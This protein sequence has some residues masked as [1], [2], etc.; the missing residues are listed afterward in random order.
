MSA[1][2]PL[3]NFDVVIIGTGSGNSILTPDFDGLRVAIVEKDVFGGTCLNRGCIPTKMFVY[4]ADVAEHIRNSAKYGIDAS[5]DNVRWSDIV[6]RVFGRIDPIP[7]NGKAYR[8]SQKN[9]TV[10]SGSARFVSQKVLEINGNDGTVQQITGTHIVIAA[11]ARPLIP[12][13]DGLDQVDYHTSDTIMRVP[14]LPKRLIIL[15][16]GYIATEM[17]H[18]FGS[19]GTEIV[20]IN[21]SARMLAREDDAVSQRFTEIY[22][23]RFECHMNSR[24]DH[25]KQ[26]GDQIT[27]HVHNDKGEHLDITGDAL[28]VSVGRIPNGDTLDL[29]KSGIIVDANGYVVTDEY[30][31]TNVGGVWAL[32]DVTNDNQLKHV[33]NAEA[34]TVAHNL[35]HP[36]SM[37]MNDLWPI[38]HAVFA[39]PQVASV[40]LTEL[41]LRHS[42]RK[43]ITAVQ[44]YGDVAYGWAME[45]T[46][47]FCKIIADPD[48]RLI[49]GAHIIGP[50]SSILIQQLIQAMKFG[51]TVDEIARGQMYIHPA[52]TEVVENA[53]LKF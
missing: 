29:D 1:A 43:F 49:L 42:G 15:G 21:R 46:E 9:T 12:E 5:I 24:V 38:P 23:K 44:D 47:H 6:D 14:E 4:A 19:F 18:V 25:V 33:A 36:E 32:G 2:T 35:I 52:L 11:G 27:I 16:A 17:A 50:Q 41:Q 34:R 39:D 53:L 10:F 45:D 7:P 31:R 51:Q 40:G 22:R 28:L 20:M 26:D 3:L 8:E 13:I 37:R 48:T 30:L